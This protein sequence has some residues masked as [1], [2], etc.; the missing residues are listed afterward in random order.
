LPIAYRKEGIQGE[1]NKKIKIEN[2]TGIFGSYAT[3]GPCD[4]N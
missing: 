2:G 3:C 4:N 1:V